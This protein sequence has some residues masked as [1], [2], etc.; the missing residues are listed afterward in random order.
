MAGTKAARRGRDQRA[1][2]RF[3]KQM[4]V[5]TEHG[6]GTT[7]N[8]SAQGVYFETDVEPRAGALVNFFIEYTLEGRPQRLLCEGKVLR[9]E[10]QG[11]RVGVAAR[12]V[13]PFFEGEESADPAKPR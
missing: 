3:D 10:P 4:S 9:V 8:I 12:L 11:D 13:A 2:V 5:R 1:S 6:E 7:H